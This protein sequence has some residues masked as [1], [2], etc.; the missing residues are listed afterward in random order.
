MRLH[1]PK[2]LQRTFLLCWPKKLESVCT[3]PRSGLDRGLP[4]AVEAV[5]ETTMMIACTAQLSQGQSGVATH[6][7]SSFRGRSCFV[8]L[9]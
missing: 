1:D 6:I 2:K 5:T 3:R 9:W 4:E 7:P 8:G